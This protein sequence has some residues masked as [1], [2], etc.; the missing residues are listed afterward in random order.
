MSKSTCRQ[1]RKQ[2]NVSVSSLFEASYV[3][4]YCRKGQT[5]KKM[6]FFPNFE[7]C[8]VLVLRCDVCLSACVS[9][10]YQIITAVAKYIFGINKICLC[11]KYYLTCH[12]CRYDYDTT[13][14]IHSRR[15]MILDTTGSS[16]SRPSHPSTPQNFVLFTNKSISGTND[17]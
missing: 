8:L 6:N 10:R 1:G 5:V 15:I 13:G 3:Q 7:P 14:S 12:D 17:F 9:E 11:R 16:L 4:K 2:E